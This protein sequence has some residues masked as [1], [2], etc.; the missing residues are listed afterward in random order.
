MRIL[1]NSVNTDTREREREERRVKKQTFREC[2]GNEAP[3][4]F[5]EEILERPRAR[6]KR[7]N[8]E[9]GKK[10]IEPRDFERESFFFNDSFYCYP[11]VIY[12][13]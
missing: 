9:G 11:H 6:A 13:F 2:G 12:S 7:E 8:G 1:I 4:I 5:D 3:F 10:V